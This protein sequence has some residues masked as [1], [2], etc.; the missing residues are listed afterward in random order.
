MTDTIKPH[1]C[2]ADDTIQ[3]ANHG[4][5]IDA[6]WEENNQLWVANSEYANTVNFCPFCGYKIKEVTN[7]QT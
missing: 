5:A 2:E 4:V 3:C 6:C 7:G 1:R